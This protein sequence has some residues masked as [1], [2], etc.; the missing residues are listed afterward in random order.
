MVNTI[1]LCNSGL[2]ESTDAEELWLQRVSLKIILGFSTA[3]RSVLLILEL[4]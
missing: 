4:F 3:R 1:A 2:A